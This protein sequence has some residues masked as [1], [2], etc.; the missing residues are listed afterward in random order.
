MPHI[1]R[2]QYGDEKKLGQLNYRAIYQ[3]RICERGPLTTTVATL[4]ALVDNERQIW[5]TIGNLERQPML[6]TVSFALSSAVALVIAAGPAMAGDV[7]N[8]EAIYKKRCKACHT[9]EAG[10]NKIGPSLFGVVGRQAGT[11]PKF[12]YS[13]SYVEAGEGGLNWTEEK[14]IEYLGNPKKYM[15][16]VTGDKKAKTKMVFKLKKEAERQDVT[17]YIATIN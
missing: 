13:K 8:G 14:I 12:K 9:I 6:K 3:S 15:R 11:V 1:L 2:F 16:S 17:A 10:K 5:I 4:V 7:G